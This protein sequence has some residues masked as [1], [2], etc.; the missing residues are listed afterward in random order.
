MPLLEIIKGEQTSDETLYRALDVAKQIKQD[1]DRR[2]RLARL[3]HLARHRHVHQRGHRDAR[4]GRPGA[5]DRAGVLAG[6][7]PGAGAAAH[8]R[9]EPEADAQDPQRGARRPRGRRAAA[10]T[11]TRPSAV[12]DRMLDE[13]ERPGKLEGAGFYE[14][15]DGKRTGLW[16][17][18]R[19][20]FPPVADPSSISL[21]RPRGADA[22]RR[23]AS[24]RSS[25]S[26]RAS[27][28]RSP[29]PTSARSWAS[30]SPAG[31]AACCS[32]STA[33]RAASPASSPARASSPSTLRRALRRRRR[34][35]SSG[36]ARRAV[37][38][39]TRGRRHRLTPRPG[40]RSC[41]PA[42]LAVL[43]ECKI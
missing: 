8:R 17:G 19:E 16:P 9:A 41:N 27:S 25:A 21:Q 15:A 6:R 36:R 20:A 30:A 35:W 39:R 37:L 32:T 43:R 34:R 13:F 31:P 5:V 26:T 2:Q 10:G 3:L 40:V 11:R 4:R 14:Y 12:I 18:L 1:A 28:S 29:T 7:L 33:T 24:R 42:T 22:V 38:R 23:G